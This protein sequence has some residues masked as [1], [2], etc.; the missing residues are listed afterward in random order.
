METETN[1]VQ[2]AILRTSL[3]IPECFAQQQPTK[4]GNSSKNGR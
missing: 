3:E 1:K 2:T 4:L